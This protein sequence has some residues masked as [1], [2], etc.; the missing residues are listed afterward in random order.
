MTKVRKNRE[1]HEIAL[2]KRIQELRKQ[3]KWSQQAAADK[4]GCIMRRWQQFEEGTNVTLGV[5][6]RLAKTLSVEPWQL[7]K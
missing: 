4:Y 2:G 7:L 5:L 6:Y 3:K 1:K